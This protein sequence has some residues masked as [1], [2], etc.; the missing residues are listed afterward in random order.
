MSEQPICVYC[1]KGPF[2]TLQEWATHACHS[3]WDMAGTIE[4]LRADLEAAQDALVQCAVIAET[5]AHRLGGHQFADDEI[6]RYTAQYL[7]CSAH[8]PKEPKP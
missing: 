4:K 3:R 2:A 1:N 5:A 7:P 8:K 6:R